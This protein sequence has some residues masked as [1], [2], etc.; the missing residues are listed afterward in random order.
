MLDTLASSLLALSKGSDGRKVLEGIKKVRAWQQGTTQIPN[1]IS[2]S[3]SAKGC[4]QWGYDIDD[5]SVVHDKLR[6]SL[7]EP[8]DRLAELAGLLDLV[9]TACQRPGGNHLDALPLQLAKTSEQMAT[10]FL[11][12]V[13]ES[14]VNEIEQSVGGK[15]LNNIPV[16]LWWTESTKRRYCRVVESAFTSSRFSTLRHTYLVEELQAATNLYIRELFQLGSLDL[17]VQSALYRVESDNREFGQLTYSRLGPVLLSKDTSSLVDKQFLELVYQ[18]LGPEKLSRPQERRLVDR[19]QPIKFAFDGR[20]NRLRCPIQLPRGIGQV[21]NSGRGLISG[22]IALTSPFSALG[23]S[24]ARPMCLSES[25]YLVNQGGS[26]LSVQKMYLL[27][28]PVDGSQQ[29]KGQI[30]WLI[31]KNDH[32]FP[33]TGPRHESMQFVR[34]FR[35]QDHVG[36]ATSR[37]VLVM[38]RAADTSSRPSRLADLGTGDRT[39]EIEYKLGDIPT[40]EVEKHEVQGQSGANG[41]Y[42]LALLRLELEIGSPTSFQVK[43]L[44]KQ[45][46]LGGATVL[47]PPCEFRVSENHIRELLTEC[48][49]FKRGMRTM[50]DYFDDRQSDYDDHSETDNEM[51]GILTDF[52]HQFEIL[53][54]QLQPILGL[55]QHPKSGFNDIKLSIRA[56]IKI[57]WNRDD[58]ENLRRSIHRKASLMQFLLQAE[59][60]RERGAKERTK[61]IM[62]SQDVQ[63][64]REKTAFDT[65]SIRTAFRTKKESIVSEG[66]AISML[67]SESDDEDSIEEILAKSGPYKKAREE[68]HTARYK[69]NLRRVSSSLCNLASDSSETE[70]QQSFHDTS[71]IPESSRPP[72]PHIAAESFGFVPEPVNLSCFEDLELVPKEP[73]DSFTARDVRAAK[74]KFQEWAKLE[75]MVWSLKHAHSSMASVRESKAKE[76]NDRLL[77]V[78]S[79]ICA[80][81]DAIKTSPKQ[82][83][84]EERNLVEAILQGVEQLLNMRVC[85]QSPDAHFFQAL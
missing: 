51:C 52:G 34:R 30:K 80:W 57:T 58:I 44:C 3:P 26:G 61:E 11:S 33:D 45:A 63:S 62:D 55:T 82:C 56:R 42:N 65:E 71:D 32:L 72:T 36:C 5:I 8:D 48:R 67:S 15:A 49:A 7:E 47:T 31:D 73:S 37:V 83:N 1:R 9:S 25:S 14:I 79:M 54:D 6:E 23:N 74:E 40:Q 81:L 22:T 18:R 4:S 41:Y 24:W 29:A 20:D 85:G 10:D 76:A 60:A 43:I 13:A 39:S 17:R 21:D 68:P 75:L 38:S 27:L 66:D 28:D 84:E 16:D 77:D 59:D 35:P 12:H 78:S 69:R 19:F 2:Y 64:L 53:R 46:V 50:R 70:T